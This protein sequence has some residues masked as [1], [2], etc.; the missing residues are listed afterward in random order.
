MTLG[1]NTI[2]RPS[3]QSCVHSCKCT[4][5]IALSL[6]YFVDCTQLENPLPQS[7]SFND[8]LLTNFSWVVHCGCLFACMVFESI[9]MSVAYLGKKPSCISQRNVPVARRNWSWEK[10]EMKR[11]GEGGI[12]PWYNAPVTEVGSSCLKKSNY[13]SSFFFSCTICG[14]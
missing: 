8:R 13:W 3:S 11:V 7:I 2:K 5:T 10:P 14:R 12:N 1:L 9:Q 6:R 4:L